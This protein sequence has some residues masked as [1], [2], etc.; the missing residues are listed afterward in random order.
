MA[1]STYFYNRLPHFR[2]FEKFTNFHSYHPLP[3]DWYV[4][5]TDVVNSTQ[6]I[7]AGQYKEV[8]IVAVLALTAI[9]NIDRSIQIPFLFGGDGVT[10]FVPPSIV[11]A[12]KDVL[13]ANQ[14]LAKDTFDFHLRCGVIPIRVLYQAEQ[15]LKV[16]KQRIA[17]RYEQVFVA[18]DGIDYAE[19]LL[20]GKQGNPSTYLVGE[21][22]EPQMPPDFTGLLC[23]FSPVLA[24]KD[25][26]LSLIVKARDPDL[27]I[28]SKIYSNVLTLIR[29]E[30]GEFRNL[31]P[32]MLSQLRPNRNVDHIRLMQMANVRIWK[33]AFQPLLK[34]FL[35]ILN[36]LP[37]RLNPVNRM[38]VLLSDY[39]KF[40]GALKMTLACQQP[41]REKLRASLEMLRQQG[42]I[43]YGTHT[44]QY[45]LIT[46]SIG[47]REEVHLID[48]ADGGYALAAKELKAQVK[49]ES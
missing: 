16:A 3:E 42:Q 20:K 46:C 22:Y 49:G 39:K 31:H 26:I 43:F 45:A 23:P 47:L 15:V 41:Q 13:V 29:Q 25:E 28:Q 11:G 40:D 27:G 7:E 36:R 34:V 44:T 19:N 17:A 8:N 4:V 32:V 18:G 2:H 14:R 6:A 30:L 12:V 5:M 37:N 21:P 38:S 35:S 1:T 24:S 10:M 48:A 33:T 9:K